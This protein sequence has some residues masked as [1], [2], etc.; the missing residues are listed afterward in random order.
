MSDDYYVSVN[1]LIDYLNRLSKQPDM[2]EEKMKALNMLIDAGIELNV[3]QV[4]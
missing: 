3:D 2:V 1:D 4:A